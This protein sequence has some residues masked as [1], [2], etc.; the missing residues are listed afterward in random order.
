MYGSDHLD[1]PLNSG[2]MLHPLMASSDFDFHVPITGLIV[3]PAVFQ[4]KFQA[5][6]SVLRNDV[7]HIN[8]SVIN[9]D[10][11]RGIGI[12]H[13]AY[14][15]V[16]NPSRQIVKC[17]IKGNVFVAQ[18]SRFR[19]KNLRQLF[20]KDQVLLPSGRIGFAAQA[21][22]SAGPQVRM[23]F[24]DFHGSAKAVIPLDGI[25]AMDSGIPG[26]GE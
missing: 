19:I 20:S 8:G 25:L 22:P 26:A 3:L 9:P 6:G 23:D 1:I 5:K 15:N 2:V 16:Q 12:D 13:P 18:D 14:G 11:L 7:V 21:C 4:N 10:M 17:D 24:C